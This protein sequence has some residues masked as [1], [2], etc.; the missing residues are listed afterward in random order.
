MTSKTTN[1]FS[2]E[3]RARAV[4]MVLDHEAEHPSRW[5]PCCARRCGAD[6]ITRRP[7]AARRD[8]VTIHDAAEP[9]GGTGRRNEEDG[10]TGDRLRLMYVDGEADIREVVEVALSLDPA[11]DARIF[12]S[13]PEAI[14]AAS[15]FAPDLLVLDVMMPGMDGPTTLAALRTLAATASTPAVSCSAMVSQAERARLL[16][17]G[18]IDVVGKPFDAM[19]LAATLRGYVRFGE[20]GGQP[21]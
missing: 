2:P 21:P 10:M 5:Q 7:G 13:G 8:G 19:T 16:A 15:D 17:T 4:R 6:E 18:A 1:K 9:P 12:G 20:S 14:A 11:I 3:V